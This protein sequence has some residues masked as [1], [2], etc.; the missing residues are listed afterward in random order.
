MTESSHPKGKFFFR[1]L[2]EE[3]FSLLFG[4]MNQPEVIRWYSKRNWT[5][6]EITDK[7]RPY[8]NGEKPIRSFISYY[9]LQPIGYIQGY[10]IQDY[11]DYL[12]EVTGRESAAG[13]D[14]YIGEEKFLH[15]GLGKYL[16]E[17]FVEEILFADPKVTSCLIGPDPN[18]QIAIRAYEKAGFRFIQKIK[19][20]EGEWE[21]VMRRERSH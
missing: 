6:E 21:Y 15:K 14:L 10:R 5:L 12:K 2:T 8:I 13:L 17:Q 4:W 16:I 9:Q 19:N 18:N 3:D 20:T 11:P 1:P 7:Y